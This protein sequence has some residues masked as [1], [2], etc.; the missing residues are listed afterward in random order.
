LNASLLRASAP[1]LRS[2]EAIIA[3]HEQI[4]DGLE[5]QTITGKVAEQMNQTL[6]GIMG[7]AKLEMQYYGLLLKF[8]RKVPVPRSPILRSVAGLPE[9][10]SPSDGERVRALIPEK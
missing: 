3:K 1:Q 4:Q 10:V 2:A 6:K 7:V 5:H 8:G 9:Q